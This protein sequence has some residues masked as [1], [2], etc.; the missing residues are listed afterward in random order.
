MGLRQQHVRSLRTDRSWRAKFEHI[1]RCSVGATFGKHKGCLV[2]ACEMPG[3]LGPFPSGVLYVSETSEDL[4][5]T[6]RMSL[7]LL[8]VSY[9]ESK[10]YGP[11]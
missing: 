4:L 2:D 9:P 11:G 6:G 8:R 10:R 7:G 5:S 3:V 1:T